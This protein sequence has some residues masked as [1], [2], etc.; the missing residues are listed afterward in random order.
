MRKYVN[1][2]IVEAICDFHFI[3]GQPWDATILGLVYDRIK[4]NFPERF[5]LPGAMVNVSFGNQ[6]T[7]PIPDLGRMQF[8]RRDGS[9]LVQLGQDNLTVNHLKPYSGWP[10]YRDMISETF[11]AYQ[12]VALPHG[13]NR[14]SLRYINRIDIPSSIVMEKNSI[15]I[16]EYLLAQPNVPDT[17]PQMFSDWAQRVVIPFDTTQ[18]TLVLQ[19]GTVQGS[20]AFPVSL[21]LDLTMSPT[22]QSASLDDVLLWLEQAHMSI[23]TVFEECLGPK[24]RDLFGLVDAASS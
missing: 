7:Q 16:E 10:Y 8:R 11:S 1:P 23:E 2:P 5:Q 24:A 3:P 4:D 21:L 17:V 12:A 13:L 15:Q 6:P 9:A 22:L 14:I 19:S 18:M 20:P